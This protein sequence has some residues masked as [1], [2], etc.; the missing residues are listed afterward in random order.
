MIHQRLNLDHWKQ[1][2]P[3]PRLRE[4]AGG[5]LPGVPGISGP[6]DVA[7]LEQLR[8]ASYA[9]SP[10]IERVPTDIFVWSRGE[11]DQR[12]VTKIGGLPYWG[13]DTPWPLGPSGTPLTFVAQICFADSQD[14]TPHLPGDLL[15]MFTEA[16]NWGSEQE[17]LYDL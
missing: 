7:V 14:L 12:F 16:K 13:A 15:L 17:P 6:L 11:P 1:R 2:F 5:R 9:N 4:K 10:G 8:D 3:L